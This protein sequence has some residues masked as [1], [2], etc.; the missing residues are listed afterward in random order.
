[1]NVDLGQMSVCAPTQSSIYD[2][3]R[4]REGV[5]FLA[6]FRGDS[7]RAPNVTRLRVESCVVLKICVRE[8]EGGGAG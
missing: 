8:G 2:N 1:M 7:S 4:S 6:T 5:L 3:G